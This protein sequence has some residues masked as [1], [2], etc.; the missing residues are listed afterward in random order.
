VSPRRTRSASPIAYKAFAELL[1]CAIQHQ[2][3]EHI[4]GE[5]EANSEFGEIVRLITRYS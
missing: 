4:G 3:G 2:L 5:D 1:A